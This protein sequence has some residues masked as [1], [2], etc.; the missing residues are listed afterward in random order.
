MNASREDRRNLL[1]EKVG[2][3]VTGIKYKVEECRC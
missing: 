1:A 2:S 3:S